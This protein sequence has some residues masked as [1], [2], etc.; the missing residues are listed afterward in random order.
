MACSGCFL[1]VERAKERSGA[2]D[3][4]AAVAAENLERAVA[5]HEVSAPAESAVA[6]TRSASEWVA[7]LTTEAVMGNIR[8]HRR[9][10]RRVRS[11]CVDVRRA[12]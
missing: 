2:D 1:I 7:S 9:N 10:D 4:H 3:R 6:R 12:R 11:I 8:P 5:G